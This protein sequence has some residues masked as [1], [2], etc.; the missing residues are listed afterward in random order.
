MNLVISI[1]LLAFCINTTFSRWT[2][3][4]VVDDY[5]RERSLRDSMRRQFMDARKIPL[6]SDYDEVS[7][8]AQI[9]NSQRDD[10]PHRYRPIT[11][12]L[13]D[14]IRYIRKYGPQAQ[15]LQRLDDEVR[16]LRFSD[17]RKMFLQEKRGE[18]H[19]HARPDDKKPCKMEVNGC[20]SGFSEDIPMVFRDLFTPCCNKHDVCYD[21]GTTDK[22]TKDECDD[23]FYYDM[24][25]MCECRYPSM[26]QYALRKMCELWSKTL[27]EVVHVF[28]GQYFTKEKKEFCKA[29]CILPHG[30]PNMTLLV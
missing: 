4:E 8:S 15:T 25:N 7:D 13:R 22:W 1:I 24:A 18:K 10:D 3:D 2:N 11:L 14:A 23:T 16:N 6:P 19:C 30:S 21:C 26:Y 27:Y 17:P 9:V 5:Y 12:P 20:G 28:G 29:K